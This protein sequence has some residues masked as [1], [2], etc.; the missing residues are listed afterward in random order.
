MLLNLPKRGLVDTPVVNRIHS[1]H[2]TNGIFWRD[3]LCELP[4]FND[5]LVQLDELLL[6]HFLELF[7][8]F[9]APMRHFVRFMLRYN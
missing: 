1:T 2:P 3:W 9:G 7:S 4:V 5:S 8:F 6:H